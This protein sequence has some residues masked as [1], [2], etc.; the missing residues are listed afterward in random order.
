MPGV[1]TTLSIVDFLAIL[2]RAYEGGAASAERI[3]TTREEI[4]HLLFMIPKSKLRRSLAL[5]L[6]LSGKFL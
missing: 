6:S 1:S 5:T 3:P 2:N 4:S